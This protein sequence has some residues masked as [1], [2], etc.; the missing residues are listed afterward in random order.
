MRKADLFIAVRPEESINIISA[1][2]A[3]QLGARKAIARI[4]NNEYLEPN[5]LSLIHI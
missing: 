2:L 5:N 1:V 3:K 4:D